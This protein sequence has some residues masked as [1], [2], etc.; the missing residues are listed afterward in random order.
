MICSVTLML[1]KSKSE[2]RWDGVDTIWDERLRLRRA[3]WNMKLR[4][5][6]RLRNK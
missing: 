3:L 6:R 4:E 2:V 1:L 5:E